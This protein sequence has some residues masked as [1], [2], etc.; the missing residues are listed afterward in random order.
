M[1]DFLLEPSPGPAP[2]LF[3]IN[4][5]PLTEKHE[6]AKRQ[7]VRAL[8]TEQISIPTSGVQTE[9]PQAGQTHEAVVALPTRRASSSRPN[10]HACTSST[11]Q[12]RLIDEEDRVLPKTTLPSPE[13]MHTD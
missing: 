13:P 12:Q 8:I 7:A 1:T 11:K 5:V 2:T 10:K 4:L 9:T 6:M 3:Q